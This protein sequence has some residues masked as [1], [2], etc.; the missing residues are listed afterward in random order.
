MKKRLLAIF[1]VLT[2]VLTILP[3]S[4]LAANQASFR[5][6]AS[7][8]W[9]YNA[10]NYAF[11]QGIMS[12]VGG[13][14]FSPETNL[15]RA[16]LCQILYNIEGKPSAGSGT[17]SDVGKSA[18]YS[19]AVNWAAAHSIVNGTGGGLFSPDGPVSREQM[20]TILHRYATYKDY[21]LSEPTTLE[22]YTDAEQLNDWAGDAM[23]WAVSE[24]I[25]SG[26]TTT[27]ISPQGSA[28]RAQAATILMR[29]CQRMEA[30]EA[31]LA[32]DM[33][34]FRGEE[35]INFDASEETNFAVLA[36]DVLVSESSAGANQIVSADED[37]GIY[38]FSNIDETISTLSPGDILYLTYGSGESDYLLFKVG[39]IKID[40]QTATVTE[41]QAELSDYFQYIDVDMDLDLSGADLGDASVVSYQQTATQP[42]YYSANSG[43]QPQMASAVAIRSI[44]PVF[45]KDISRTAGTSFNFTIGGETA[46]VSGSVNLTLELKICYDKIIFDIAEISL[47]VKQET[48]LKGTVSHSITGK[49]DTYRKET[50]ELTIPVVGG[51]D[52]QVKAYFKF[53]VDTSADG[54][55][56]ATVTTTN[57]TKYS[58]GKAQHI[59]E[60][61]ADVST[62]IE[63]SF[64]I[65]AGVGVTGSIKVLK[66]LKF[67]LNGEAGVE[68]DATLEFFNGSILH[69]EKHLCASCADGTV[70]AYFELGLTVTLG[71][72]EKISWKIVD[73]KLA[74]VKGELA[75]FY[76]SFLGG[77]T[78]AEFDWGV[79]PH[80]QYLV[81]VNAKDQDGNKI[82]GASIEVSTK[83]GIVAR[84]EST[85]D[86][87]F[88]AYCDN[89]DYSVSGILDGYQTAR[90]SVSV[91]SK[92]CSVNLTL[93]NENNNL[94]DFEIKDGVLI[95]YHGKGGAV[96]I[97]SGVTEIGDSAFR[98]CTSLTSV[99]IPDSVTRIG[100]MAFYGCTGLTSVTIPNSVTSI[101]R[102]VFSGCTG[103]TSVTIP[104]SVTSIEQAAFAHC[105]GLTSVTFGSGLRMIGPHTAANYYALEGTF[106]GCTGLT[107]V[108]IPDGVTLIGFCT[109]EGCTGLTSIAIPASVTTI[110]DSIFFDCDNLENIYYSGTREQWAEIEITSFMGGFN[111]NILNLPAGVTIH[112]NSTM[113]G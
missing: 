111:G 91:K 47:S 32:K 4:A 9:Y 12:G 53:D 33:D 109:F 49:E 64:N 2:M 86:G 93:Q 83:D 98:E 3:I 58:G 10:V 13:N 46:N 90:D 69:E 14:D 88:T 51:I 26:T 1:L 105:T 50:Q 81:T 52:A 17:F 43:V 97:P 104:D 87:V 77:D 37:E 108:V 84:G 80:K 40:G 71:I 11:T 54:S 112:F 106:E 5:D 41:G 19:N 8:A 60:S 75:K 99:T 101:E 63:G 18:W 55:I 48:T 73:F 89:G 92:A 57:G 24:G 78:P 56:S 34:D 21:S 72:S 38:V 70:D 15:T 6:V 94:N 100:S 7:D 39:T 113:P 42:T 107:N 65:T 22:N 102:Y 62:D 23:C 16:Q 45:A 44:P 28:T 68:L 76:I 103:L 79:C 25:I 35:I 96:T 36:E 31:F 61:D 95:N 27:T 59:K 85:A 66:V 74:Q 82:A 20:V 29:F 30:K 67:S 110:D